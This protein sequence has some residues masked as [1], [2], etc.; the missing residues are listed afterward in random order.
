MQSF[1]AM[2]FIEEDKCI[3]F[4]HSPLIL[5]NFLKI[6]NPYDYLHFKY[7][8]NGLSVKFSFVLWNCYSD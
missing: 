4:L 6:E 8:S 2:A 7:I 1:T 3:L 5:R